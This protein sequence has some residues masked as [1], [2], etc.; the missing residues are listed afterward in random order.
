MR[1]ELII[2]AVVLVPFALLV[3]VGF[4]FTGGTVIPGAT[5]VNMAPHP[6]PLPASLGEGIPV[7]PVIDAGPRFPPE[8]AAPL[9]AILPEVRRCFADQHFKQVH[10]VQVRF[11]P[12]RDGGFDQVSVDEQNPYLAACL[13]DVLIEVTWHPEGPETFTPAS[14]TFSFGPSP[15]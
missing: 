3:G 13:E 10:E 6:D 9:K 2:A 5:V 7:L 4:S 8:L 14:H 11:T 15:D 1:R 12:T